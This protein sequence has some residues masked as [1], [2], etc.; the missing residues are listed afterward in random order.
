MYIHVSLCTLIVW[1]LYSNNLCKAAVNLIIKFIKSRNCKLNCKRKQSISL[2][3]AWTF[4]RKENTLNRLLCERREKQKKFSVWLRDCNKEK[5]DKAYPKKR[6]KKSK[7]A[8][9]KCRPW[10]S[11]YIKLY[12]TW[13]N[14]ERKT[15]KQEKNADKHTTHSWRCRFLALALFDTL[16]Y[17]SSLFI[18]SSRTKKGAPQKGTRYH[19][20]IAAVAW[21]LLYMPTISK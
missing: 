21:Y 7:T 5:F 3:F 8:Y 4:E 11:H 14:N 10:P 1:E 13:V 19:P 20:L 18:Y 6:R 2:K 9:K 16:Y 15:N 17:L 12:N